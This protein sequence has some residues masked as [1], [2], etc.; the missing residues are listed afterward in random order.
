MMIKSDSLIWLS[1]LHQKKKKKMK[2]KSSR[3]VNILLTNSKSKT[4]IKLF[5]KLVFFIIK[6]DTIQT[7]FRLFCP[8]LALTVNGKLMIKKMKIK[9]LI[10][11]HTL[12]IVT[13]SKYQRS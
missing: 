13:N 8:H 5:S 3:K 11:L 9:K 1:L 6:N 10:K 12:F 2:K 7:I 4:V